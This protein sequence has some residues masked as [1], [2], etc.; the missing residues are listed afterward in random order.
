MQTKIDSDVQNTYIQLGSAYIDKLQNLSKGLLSNNQI[1]HH[2][3]LTK[4]I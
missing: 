2:Q 3:I 4:S 1:Q